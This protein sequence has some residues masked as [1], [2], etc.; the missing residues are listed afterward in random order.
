MW[1]MENS[2]ALD[3]ARQ[4]LEDKCELAHVMED[5]RCLF[6][7]EDE[8]WAI[9]EHGMRLAPAADPIGLFPKLL[10]TNS[11]GS[12]EFT[13]SQATRGCKLCFV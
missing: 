1:L 3:A 2:E 4:R 9:D 11:V 6:L 7:C 13:S 10:S 8:T 12:H 5:G